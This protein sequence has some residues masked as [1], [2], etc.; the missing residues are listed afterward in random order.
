ME[1]QK[2]SRIG[3]VIS[4][5]LVLLAATAYF[6]LEDIYDAYRLYNYTPPAAIV[7]IADDVRFSEKGRKLFYVNHPVLQDKAAFNQ[8]CTD[9]EATIVLGCYISHRGIYL[10][11][12][13]DERLEGVEEVTAAHEMLHAAYDRL[14][15]RDRQRIDALT[16][17]AF[18]DIKSERIKNNVEEYRKKDPTVVP[19]ELHSIIATEVRDLDP[20]LEAYYKQYFVDRSVVVSL[21]E[22][23][24]NE[25]ATRDAQRQAYDA[26]LE[27]LKSEIDQLNADLNTSEQRLQQDYR[28]L[29]RLRGS[30]PSA[31]NDRVPGYNQQVNAYNRKVSAVQRLIN[32]YNETIEKRNALVLEE[33]ELLEAIDSRPEAIESQ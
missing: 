21:S 12:I 13:N 19:N 9:S 3:P 23:Y 31:Y 11:D 29:Q 5:L 1:A 14:S 17:N 25:F 27:A 2:Q 32:E 28:E 33:G 6:R 10:Y 22:K 18:D 7:A 16:Q 30:D 20:E 15:S 24:E 26:Q 8:S 4:L